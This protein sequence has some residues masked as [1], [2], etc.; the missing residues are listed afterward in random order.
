MVRIVLLGTQFWTQPCQNGLATNFVKRYTATFTTVASTQEKDIGG[1]E[2]G[3][4][5]DMGN[6]N[7]ATCFFLSFKGLR[8]GTDIDQCSAAAEGGAQLFPSVPV[9]LN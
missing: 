9:T 5:E 3:N 4:N 6:L 8:G 7:D 1:G 2:E